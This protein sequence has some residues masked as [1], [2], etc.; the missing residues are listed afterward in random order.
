MRV[1]V[2]DYGRG[3]LFSLARALD[4]VGASHVFTEAPDAVEHAECLIL[5]GVGAFADAMAALGE[6]GLVEPLRRAAAQGTPLL[7]ICLGMQ[8]LA[9][10]GEEFGAHEGLGLIPGTVKRLPEGDGRPNSLRIP[11]VG[12]RP[13]TL[14]AADPILEHA[15]ADTMFYFVHSFAPAVDDPAHVSATVAFNGAD[16]AAV[17]RKDRVVGT[18]FHPEKSGPAGLALLRRFVTVAERQLQAA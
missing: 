7:G 11:N 8:V 10:R 1:T 16:I 15:D 18:Q 17:I 2:V 4:H 6:R 12:W 5:P 9:T 13:L 3:N 14:H